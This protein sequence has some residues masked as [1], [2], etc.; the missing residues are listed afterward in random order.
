[1]HDHSHGERV[2]VIDAGI[3]LHSSLIAPQSQS[4]S[5]LNRHSSIEEPMEPP[6][7]RFS[8]TL[9]VS[10]AHGI[11]SDMN[12]CSITADIGEIRQFP[13]PLSASVQ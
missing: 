3:V 8:V 1:M 7:V 12:R 10:S 9:Q 11:Q 13:K 5:S 2:N 6:V 4:R